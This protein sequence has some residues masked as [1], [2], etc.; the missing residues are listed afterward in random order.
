MGSGG[1][2]IGEN[3]SECQVGEISRGELQSGT[4]PDQRLRLNAKPDWL[5]GCPVFWC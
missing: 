1:E 3:G 2:G 4:G 5:D